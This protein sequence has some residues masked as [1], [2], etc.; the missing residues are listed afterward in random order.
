MGPPKSFLLASNL[1]L[2][3]A[4]GVPRKQGILHCSHL[5]QNGKSIQDTLYSIALFFFC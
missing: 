1:N 3:Q 4:Y 2:E 5:Y